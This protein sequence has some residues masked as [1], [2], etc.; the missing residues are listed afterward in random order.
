MSAQAVTTL[1]ASTVLGV[2]LLQ[3]ARCLPACRTPTAC[4]HPTYSQHRQ[5]PE[6]I[7]NHVHPEAA[8]IKLALPHTR[9]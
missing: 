7:K 8:H 2:F 6:Q 5:R 9:R 1:P 4:F 3:R